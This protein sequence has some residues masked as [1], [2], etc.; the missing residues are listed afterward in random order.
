MIG[1]NLVA[2]QY[3]KREWEMQHSA[4]FYDDVVVG[5]VGKKKDVDDGKKRK[6]FNLASQ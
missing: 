1:Y 5:E 3:L 6:R 4:E 2:L